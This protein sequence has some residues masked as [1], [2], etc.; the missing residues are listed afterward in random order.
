[1]AFDVESVE[2]QS[3]QRSKLKQQISNPPTSQG[4][5]MEAL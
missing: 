5:L 2:N 3:T 4:K 1:M